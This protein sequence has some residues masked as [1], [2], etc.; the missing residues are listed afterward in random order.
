[1]SNT[2]LAV[3]EPAAP[4]LDKSSVAF[5]A[6]SACLVNCSAAM[7]A[8]FT[9]PPI[10]IP[11]KPKFWPKLNAASPALLNALLYFAKLFSVDNNEIPNDV[12]LLE[13]DVSAALKLP[14]ALA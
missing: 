7:V 3:N 10:A 14:M 2:S 5:N 4:I 12:K 6:E 1:M 11:T 8:T 13:L 9:N